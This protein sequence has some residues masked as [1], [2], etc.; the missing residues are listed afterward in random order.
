MRI[1]AD[2]RMVH[3]ENDYLKRKSIPSFVTQKFYDNHVVTSDK[4]KNIVVISK[5]ISEF[6]Y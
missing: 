1:R 2:P 5:P 6:V 3:N 4:I